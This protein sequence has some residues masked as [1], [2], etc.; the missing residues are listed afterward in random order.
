MDEQAKQPKVIR[1]DPRDFI[2][3]PYQQCPRCGHQ[4]FG[5]LSIFE[6][7]YVRRCRDCWHTDRFELP[8]LEKKVIYV[9]QFAISNMMK[10]LNPKTKAHQAGKVEERWLELFRRLDHLSKLQLV[11]CPD[12]GFHRDESLVSPFND[13][14]RRMYELLSGG[15][16]FKDR[17]YI[18]QLQL[19]DH[20]E[21]WIQGK[22]REPIRMSPDDVIDGRLHGWQDRLIISVNTNVPE[23]W[24]EELRQQRERV[25]EALVEIHE[26]WRTKDAAFEEAFLEEV[27]GYGEAL[28]RI[29]VDH[30]VK[31]AR[32]ML[33]AEEF[34]L[35]TISPPPAVIT[36]H[37][38]ED[39][40]RAAGVAEE[41]LRAK[42]VEY[43]S[44]DDLQYVPFVRIKCLLFAAMA[45]RARAGQKRPPNRGLVSDIRMVS[46]LLPYCD[47]ML[48]DNE[49]ASYV[50]EQ[51]LAREVE[52]F[53][54]SVFSPA[55][56][57]DIMRYLDEVEA[58]AP[59]DH[60]A[61]IR[62]VYGPDWGKP[63]ETVYQESPPQA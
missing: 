27:R 51:P 16:S 19:H 20:I 36:I 32:V 42:V 4:A 41:N 2:T 29:Y 52:N 15:V 61:K 1:I 22:A 47:A 21:L 31:L 53:G 23:E 45:R 17:S 49:V 55:T 43:L 14:L 44:S 58:A 40:L 57:G 54:T 39:T 28:R 38:L 6:R 35:E 56:L 63:F 10:A 34:S 50:R 60:L 9:D 24:I 30:V 48:V 37:I 3:S 26:Q 7:H 25:H 62:E 46:C 13:A 5:V 18:E 59:P 11:I 12:S 33:G 8:P